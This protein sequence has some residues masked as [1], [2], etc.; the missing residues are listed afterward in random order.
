MNHRAN[1]RLC[2]HLRPCRL[3][4]GLGLA[5]IILAGG[6]TGAIAQPLA[7]AELLQFSGGARAVGDPL[8]LGAVQ[9]FRAAAGVCAVAFS[10]DG[11]W[12]AAGCRDATVLVWGTTS[13][14]E[15]HSLRSHKADVVSLAFS[16]RR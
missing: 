7:G 9:Q 8:P 1:H 6:W 3:L 14:K 15:R 10:P 2:R 16:S 13:G 5:A 12:L 11:K 4:A